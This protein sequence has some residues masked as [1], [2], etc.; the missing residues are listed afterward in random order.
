M[1]F[2]S[3]A[4]AGSPSPLIGRL[5]THDSEHERK[6]L[7]AVEDASEVVYSDHRLHT[8]PGT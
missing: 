1:F 6:A 7:E 2:R 5:L 4:V 3:S 8:I